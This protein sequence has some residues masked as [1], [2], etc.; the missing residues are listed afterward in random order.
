MRNLLYIYYWILN[1]WGFIYHMTT[2]LLHGPRFLNEIMSWKK[3]QVLLILKF[4]F[5]VLSLYRSIKLNTWISAQ[6]KVEYLMFSSKPKHLSLLMNFQMV[7]VQN[8][9][10]K[11]LPRV[12]TSDRISSE[13]VHGLFTVHCQW[14]I[15]KRPKRHLE[16]SNSWLRVKCQDS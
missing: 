5:L 6:N 3:V 2:N 14:N 8:I 4:I 11:C 1:F 16:V 12:N 13:V 10:N 9:F 15:L 7:M